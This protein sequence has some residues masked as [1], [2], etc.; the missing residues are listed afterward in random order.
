MLKEVNVQRTPIIMIIH[1]MIP[2][3]SHK[4]LP[5]HVKEDCNAQ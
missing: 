4:D 2:L 3:K 5:M 1:I